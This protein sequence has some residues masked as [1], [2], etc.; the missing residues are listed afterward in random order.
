M[1]DSNPFSKYLGAD[2]EQST[3][4]QVDTNNHFA[5]YL[6]PEVP[7][8]EE[9]SS[10]FGSAARG[11]ERGVLPS[12]AGIAG[13]MATGAAAGSAFPGL[14]TLGGAIIGGI[15]GIGTGY[16]TSV[17]QDYAL[18]KAPESWQD[19]LGGTEEQQRLDREQHP[20]ASFVGGM[21]PFAITMRPGGFAKP[22]GYEQLTNFQ[23]MLAH[24]VTSRLFG[25]SVV[26]G[27]ELGQELLSGE[28]PDWADVATAT[29]FGMVFNKPWGLGK[30]IEE[31]AGRFGPK[32]P[33]PEPPPI[34]D[35]EPEPNAHPFHLDPENILSMLREQSAVHEEVT[36]PPADYS[37]DIPGLGAPGF[38][39]PNLA[40]A[41]DLGIIGAGQIEETHQKVEQVN[42][43]A[44]ASNQAPKQ[45]E[46]IIQGRSPVLEDVEKLRPV[47]HI[48]SYF[49][50]MRR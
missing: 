4:T 7:E 40:D 23:K 16:G 31:R 28:K 11:F 1:D 42:P 37:R 38:W 35:V 24:P 45:A 47:L 49:K 20:Y 15:G 5:K 43:E 13:G 9:Q 12:L 18:S 34:P 21:L 29:A 41:A 27:V 36:T 14:G 48:Q 30:K 22:E 17:A 10:T 3:P 25:G 6:E 26:G 44:E 32:K 19:A 8:P 50:T 46:M 33:E 2:D 39:E